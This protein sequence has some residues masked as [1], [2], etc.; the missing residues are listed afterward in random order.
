M[1]EKPALDA[2][3]GELE[4]RYSGSAD[5][6]QLLRDV[7]LGIALSDAGRDFEGEVDVRVVELIGKHSGVE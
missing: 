1:L 5:Y 6:D 4:K 7:H 2:L 3:F